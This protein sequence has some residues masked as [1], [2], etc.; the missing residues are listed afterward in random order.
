[1]PLLKYLAL[2]LALVVFE[3]FSQPIIH[4]NG[5]AKYT[6]RQVVELTLNPFT[7]PKQMVISNRIFDKRI[8]W[9]NYE[10]PFAWTLEA[11]DGKKTVY[12]RFKNHNDQL[13]EQYSASI[14]LDTQAPLI[15]YFSFDK[16]DLTNKASNIL[17]IED[18]TAYQMLISDESAFG[19]SQWTYY[20]K[21]YR[22]FIRNIVENKTYTVYL[23]VRDEAYNESE[24]AQ[25]SITFDQTPPTNYKIEISP[26]KF[27]RR[28]GKNYLVVD[29]TALKNNRKQKIKIE[30]PAQDAKYFR[31]TD[32]PNFKE[33]R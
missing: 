17:K 12:V 8:E 10:S 15:E 27:D 23:K 25:T 19:N 3:T 16:G 13:S 18:E 26:V 5:G 4:L 14:I 20:R 11:G 9:I 29:R 1:M 22:Y 21:N 32:Q 24:V 7:E 28:T 6:S 33:V 31:F 30:T 2:L